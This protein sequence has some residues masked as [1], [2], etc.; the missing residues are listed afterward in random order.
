MLR[1]RGSSKLPLNHKDTAALDK[2]FSGLDGEFVNQIETISSY[3]AVAPLDHWEEKGW[4]R[5]GCLSGCN[6][7]TV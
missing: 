2:I 1:D 6:S 4:V 5:G 3:Y 7:S